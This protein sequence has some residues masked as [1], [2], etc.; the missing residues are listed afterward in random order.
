[1]EGIFG[2]M[3]M[4]V[5]LVIAIIIAIPV[6][7]LIAREKYTEAPISSGL[8]GGIITAAVSFCVISWCLLSQ[9]L[10]GPPSPFW[11]P[12][13][14]DIIGVWHLTEYTQTYLWEKGYTL[15]ENILEFRED[16]TYQ[17]INEPLSNGGFRSDSGTWK[18][19]RVQGHWVI[20]LYTDAGKFNDWFWLYGRKP[21]Y[22]IYVPW[23][24]LSDWIF[25]E[26]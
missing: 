16:G 5:A 19:D 12:S 15:S 13:Q 25:Y 23:A 11:K 18:V 10:A 22:Q 21:P 8:I 14:K 26:R 4:V 1:M 20:R 24:E 3:T 2:C 6:G 7:C 17:I 9:V